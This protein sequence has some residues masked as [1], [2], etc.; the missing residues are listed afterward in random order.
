VLRKILAFGGIIIA[1]ELLFLLLARYNLLTR[2]GGIHA[3]QVHGSVIDG[4]TGNPVPRAHVLVE[5]EAGDWTSV[6]ICFGV[7]ADDQGVF[8]VE[9]SLPTG[10]RPSFQVIACAPDDSVGYDFTESPQISDGTMRGAV[11]VTT[12]PQG[13][14]DQVRT[15]Y[16]YA[17]FCGT[18]PSDEIEFIGES[19]NPRER[20]EFGR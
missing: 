14:R 19:W 9:R 1:G 13:D 16:K 8:V 17:T 10:V 15:K 3:I 12:Q 18:C 20:D 11:R 7:I 4:Q 6:P 2:F 5:L